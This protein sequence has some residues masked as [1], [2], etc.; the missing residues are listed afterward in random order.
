MATE[1]F[2][3]SYVELSVVYCC[4]KFERNQYADVQRQANTLFFF[5]L[6]SHLSRVFSL[7]YG[8]NKI[9]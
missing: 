7:E 8:L 9:I 5:F 1:V 4:T 3:F 6:D 2:A